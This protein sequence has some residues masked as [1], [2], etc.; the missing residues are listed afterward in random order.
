MALNL[1]SNHVHSGPQNFKI[2]KITMLFVCVSLPF[3]MKS[4]MRDVALEEKQR[5]IFLIF[6]DMENKRREVAK[7]WFRSDEVSSHL[8]A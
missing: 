2:S 4:G 6:Y 1:V 3:C 8:P 5:P 7:L